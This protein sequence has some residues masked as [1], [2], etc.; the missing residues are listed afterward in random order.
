MI[1]GKKYKLTPKIKPYITKQEKGMPI[2]I[3]DL[4]PPTEIIGVCH[5]SGRMISVI[6]DS[7]GAKYC[8]INVEW[9]M[10]EINDES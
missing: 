1:I 9:V 5:R 8:I 2:A 3:Y 10:E 7:D 6:E 4:N